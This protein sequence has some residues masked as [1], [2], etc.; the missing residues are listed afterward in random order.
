ML[1]KTQLS[2]LWRKCLDTGDHVSE[3]PTCVS[4]G[5]MASAHPDLETGSRAA[6]GPVGAAPACEELEQIG[7]GGLARVLS[8]WDR[9]R[10]A[11]WR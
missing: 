11:R 2:D 7:A 3:L 8:A 4:Y 1:D 5:R 9:S 6:P 10:G